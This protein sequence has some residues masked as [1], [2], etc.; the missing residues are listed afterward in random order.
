MLTMPTI[1]MRM[2]MTMAMM[3]WSMKNLAIV[4]Y[5]VSGF[6]VGAGWDSDVAVNGL[7][8][9]VMPAFTLWSPSATTCSPGFNPA[10]M[11]H[12]GPMRSATLTG[13]ISI[14]LSLPTTAT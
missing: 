9:T 10:S 2:E 3:G 1:T 6:A 5:L 14:L 4:I 8:L 13:L 7:G 11:I 12:C